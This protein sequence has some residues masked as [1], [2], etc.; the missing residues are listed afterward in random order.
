MK[1]KIIELIKV[2]GVG[3][4]ELVM[5]IDLECGLF[6]SIEYDVESDKIYLH[7][8]QDEESEM[9]FDFE[10]LEDNDQLKVYQILAIFYN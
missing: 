1:T 5:Y 8:F 10:D 6:E 4:Y 2:L 7:I 9:M 3:S